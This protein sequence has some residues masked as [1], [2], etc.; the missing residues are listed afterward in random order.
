MDA[1][2]SDGFY[3]PP[4]STSGFLTEPP[5]AVIVGAV[6][7]A[8]PTIPPA[9]ITKVDDTGVPPARIVKAEDTGTP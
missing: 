3:C 8:P 7:T 2:I 9:R 1:F 6:D 4:S 5:P